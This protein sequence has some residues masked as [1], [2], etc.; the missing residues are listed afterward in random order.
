MESFHQE[1]IFVTL[2]LLRAKGAHGGTF[3]RKYPPL[4]KLESL[5]KARVT[6]AHQSQAPFP[7][8]PQEL[9]G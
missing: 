8:Q 1:D 3:G 7:L 9:L 2:P 4:S 5:Q 6:L